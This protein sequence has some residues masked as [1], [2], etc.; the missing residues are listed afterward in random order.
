MQTTRILSGIVI[1]FSIFSCSTNKT[2]SET[3]ETEPSKTSI[4][5]ITLDPGHFHSALVQK[6]MYKDVDSVVHVFAP[7]GND[8]KEHLK[9]I[10]AYNN[11]TQDPTRWK[12]EV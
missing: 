7:E 8:V 12:E 9:K 3:V 2:G 5:L 10:D 6:P 11:R 1:A 4:R